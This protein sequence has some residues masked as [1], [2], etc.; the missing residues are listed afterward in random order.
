MSCGLLQ[1]KLL[2]KSSEDTLF[3]SCKVVRWWL[4]EECSKINAYFA[5]DQ[6]DRDERA[7][8][9]DE[10]VMA[11]KYLQVALLHWQVQ[12]WG[13]NYSCIIMCISMVSGVIIV[14][15]DVLIDE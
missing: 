9:T 12:Y 13:S 10:F 5:S 1:S 15:I 4:N 3:E 11:L 2:V 7:V 6:E 14:A 8:T